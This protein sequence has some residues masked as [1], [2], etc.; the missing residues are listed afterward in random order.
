VTYSAIKYLLLFVLLPLFSFSQSK[1][2]SFLTPSDTLN[3]PRRN[4][5]VIAETSLASMSLV[6][7]H[8][9]WY[10]DYE[11]SKLHAINDN[12]E[13]LQ[14]DKVGHVFTSYQMGKHGAQLLNW[15]GV[16]KKDQLIYGATLG[17]GFLTTVEV[18]DGYS[19]EW[20]FSWG[21][22]LANASGTG[23]YVGQELL[24][25]EQRIALKFSFHQTKY[26]SQRSDKLGA[27]FF[28]EVLKDYN[29]Q[30]YWL[31]A[32]LHSFFKEK[33]IPKWLN[34][35]V[36]YGADGMLT[37]V[38][39]VDNQ[40]LTNL[41]RQRQFYLSLDVNLSNIETNSKLL[42][43]FLDVFNMI[44]IPFPTIEFNKKGCVFRLFYY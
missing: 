38:K 29:G 18:L 2:D 36:G 19:Q 10:A 17:F 8:Q 4:T 5:V 42:K 37:G 39:D 11:Q 40:L 22:I 23:L 3:K 32:N 44:K 15:S 43:T 28:E 27:G 6:G 31:S 30:T 26:A 33:S 41:D 12:N 7:L 35:A 16:S 20:G 9:L 1:L 14:M 24:W 13:W 21:D 34:I 25:N